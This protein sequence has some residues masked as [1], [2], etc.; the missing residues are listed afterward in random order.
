VVAQTDTPTEAVIGSA[1]R[2]VEAAW[3]CD[4]LGREGE[5]R[6]V[7]DGVLALPLRPWQIATVQLRLG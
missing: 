2:P 4:L 7:R 1:G 3:D 6:P 5:Q